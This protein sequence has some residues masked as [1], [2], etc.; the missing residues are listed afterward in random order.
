[1]SNIHIEEGDFF[2][3]EGTVFHLLKETGE[4]S[5][6][7]EVFLLPTHLPTQYLWRKVGQKIDNFCYSSTFGK[8]KC[9]RI[10]V[11]NV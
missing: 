8:S 5:G 2:K 11:D 7:V 1:M 10:E 6:T 3:C 4:D 9:T